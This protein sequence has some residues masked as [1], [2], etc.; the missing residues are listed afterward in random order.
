MGL[1]PE[2]ETFAI[3]YVSGFCLADAWKKLLA[4]RI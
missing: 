2:L 3:P 1:I 4:S